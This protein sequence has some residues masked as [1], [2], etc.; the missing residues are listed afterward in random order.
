V[1]RLPAISTL[2]LALAVGAC[3]LVPTGSPVPTPL[4]GPAA[5]QLCNETDP[6]SLPAVAADLQTLQAADDPA[7]LLAT[8]GSTLA[9][10]E[11]LQLDPASEAGEWR[12]AA[13]DA[14]TQIQQRIGEPDRRA[15][16]VE[17]GHRTLGFFAQR[18]CP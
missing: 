17:H 18:L 2:F 8:L 11:Q 12:D 10:I 5:A 3:S 9:L 14:I 15:A 1:S 7:V 16:L 4:G 6:F 13:A